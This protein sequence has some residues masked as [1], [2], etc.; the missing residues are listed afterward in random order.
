MEQT[1]TVH[2]TTPEGCNIF[3][4]V[5]IEPN[6]GYE[7]IFDPIDLG[8]CGYD[9]TGIIEFDDLAGQI[10]NNIISMNGVSGESQNIT[11]TIEDIS[12]TNDKSFFAHSIRA[13]ATQYYVTVDV[14]Y[15][16][17][18]IG[19]NC[20]KSFTL[21]FVCGTDYHAYWKADWP[22]AF[23]ASQGIPFMVSFRSINEPQAMPNCADMSPNK[24]SI[25]SYY[26][27]VFT[28]W[29]E[30]KF[31]GFFEVD[32]TDTYGILGN[33]IQWDGT[34]PNSQFLNTGVYTVVVEVSSCF[35]GGI[36]CTDCELNQSGNQGLPFQYC[37][38]QLGDA[39]FAFTLQYFQ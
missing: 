22:N 24:S 25:Y 2:V 17:C 3:D 20:S 13:V 21:D 1:Y 9:I 39:E 31:E 33:E 11:F 5:K 23:I 10:P 34:G 7:V 28:S 29:G 8:R 32:P 30:L 38:T 14:D 18:N 6:D 27:G 37:N 15:G 35:D 19:D 36:T 16:E 26:L 4:E 12:G